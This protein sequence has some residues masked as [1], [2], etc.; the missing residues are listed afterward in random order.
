MT[1]KISSFV[2]TILLTWMFV[3]PVTALEVNEPELESVSPDAVVFINYTGPH[4]VIDS[5]EQIKNIGSS[6]GTV[7]AT[8]PESAGTAGNPARYYVIHAV[9]PETQAGLD[10]D[11]LIVGENATVDHIRNLRHIIAAYL[12]AAYNYSEQDAQTLAVFITVYNA[13][14]RGNMDAFN[15]KYK[16]VVTQNLT[17]DKAGLALNYQDWP[18]KSQIVIPLSNP[19]GGLSTI[20]TGVIS[21]K[22]VV[23]SLREE[24]D[25]GIDVRKDLVD[26]KEREADIAEEQAAEAQK[27]AV[28]ETEKQQQEEQKLAEVKKEAETAQEEAETARREAE[29][30]PDDVEAQKEAEQKAQIAEEKQQEV[31]EQTQKNQEQTQIAEEK[32]QEAAEQQA[33]ADQKREEARIDRTEIAKDQQKLILAGRT[34]D[35]DGVYGLRILDDT[36]STMVKL[37]KT[38]GSVIKESPVT[39]IRGRTLL[40][41]GEN[42]M[43]I[44]GRTGG[45]AAVKVVLLDTTNMEIVA[46]SAEF[47]SEQSVLVQDGDAY[48]AVI[49]DTNGWV[50]GKYNSDLKLLL[51]SKITVHPATPVTVTEA[52][53]CVTAT[54]GSAKLL[55]LSNLDEI[56]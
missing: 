5:L 1:R 22:Q 50:L 34:P 8:N 3:I 39:V 33:V 54:D 41:A 52:G 7:I 27:Q 47:A 11:I 20:D 45:N 37:N 10:A 43:A 48:Y 13:V 31:E 15:S 38:N 2:F 46:E 42:Y 6:L 40:P 29:A 49:Q 19:T 16:P 28:Q 32:R 24:E 4:T 18:G 56:K 44:A 35:A 21:D 51:K 9:D 53:I 25:M 26:I 14:Y 12:T 30:N 17:S 23:E 36:F 55:S